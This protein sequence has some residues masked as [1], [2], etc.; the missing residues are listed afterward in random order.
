MTNVLLQ[1]DF[2]ELIKEDE[3]QLSIMK[4]YVKDK[5]KKITVLKV[6]NII[7]TLLLI[8]L[9]SFT[10]TIYQQNLNVQSTETVIKELNS[11]SKIELSAET[12]HQVDRSKNVSRN[13]KNK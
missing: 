3:L 5:N 4:D 9:L 7:L 12:P 6:A 8:F 1:S 13:K 2:E 11:V 10:V